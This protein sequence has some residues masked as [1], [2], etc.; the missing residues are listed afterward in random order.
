[1]LVSAAVVVVGIAA[2]LPVLAG[3][4]DFLAALLAD[5]LLAVLFLEVLVDVVEVVMMMMMMM[6]TVPVSGNDR[7]HYYY[8][9]PFCSRGY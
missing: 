4:A 8:P 6:M 1:M 9:F 3:T 7:F 2:A 5:F